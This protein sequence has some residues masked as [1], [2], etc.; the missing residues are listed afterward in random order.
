MIDSTYNTNGTVSNLTVATTSNRFSSTEKPQSTHFDQLQPVKMIDASVPPPPAAAAAVTAAISDD[1]EEDFDV[2]IKTT[3]KIENEPRRRQVS[4]SLKDHP[5]KSISIKK[6][7]STMKQKL[8]KKTIIS[9]YDASKFWYT[10]QEIKQRHKAIIIASKAYEERKKLFGSASTTPASTTLIPSSS[11]DYSKKTKKKTS[12]VLSL[13]TSSAAMNIEDE[14]DIQLLQWFSSERRKQRM[15]MRTQMKETVRALKDF[16]SSTNT[17]TQPELL[18]QL[19]QRHSKFAVDEA[20]RTA[21]KTSSELYHH[22]HKS[23][24]TNI[25]HVIQNVQGI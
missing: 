18:C 23:I 10:R 21:Y 11:I 1:E 22:P 6:K 4:F 14:D 5:S 20:I 2:T 13:L 19:L 8:K 9:E 17:K 12:S 16:E 25:T 3:T 7:K 24:T 15:R